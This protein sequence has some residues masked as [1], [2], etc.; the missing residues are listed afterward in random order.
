M[1]RRRS[2]NRPHR[3]HALSELNVTPLLDLCFCLLII[4][5]IA[6]PV[7]EQTTQIDL[8]V[9]S[10]GI[11]TP[12][13]D[14]PPPTRIVAIDRAGQLVFDGKVTFLS[15][16]S[17]EFRRIAAL[18]QDQQPVIRIRGDGNVAYQRMIELFSLAKES[19]ITKVGL[20]T[21]VK[22]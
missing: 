16:L 21:E 3:M 8:P 22:D 17:E 4:F 15:A 10:K 9:A 7:L 20:D 14:K 6:T 13:P 1:A 11:A 12:Q 5:M 18:P 19:G 2:F